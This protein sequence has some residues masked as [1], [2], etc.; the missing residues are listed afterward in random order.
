MSSNT[1]PLV[2]ADILHGKAA[3]CPECGGPVQHSFFADKDRWGYGLLECRKCTG[4][5]ILSR[6]HF[7]DNVKD[8]KPMEYYSPQ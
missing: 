6:V 3:L 5:F 1:W 4:R 2:Y 7:P 8:V